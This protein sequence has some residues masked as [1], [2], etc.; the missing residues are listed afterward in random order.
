M[1]KIGS[2]Y[3]YISRIIKKR[4]K[5]SQKREDFFMKQ[6]DIFQENLQEKLPDF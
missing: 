5:P 6:N 1:R 2:L 4:K 3:K